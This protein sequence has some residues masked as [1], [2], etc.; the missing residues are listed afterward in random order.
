MTAVDL[1][2]NRLLLKQIQ[3]RYGDVNELPP[4]MLELVTTISQ[5]Y[6]QYEKE[7]QLIERSIDLSSQEMLE[8]NNKLEQ[9][10]QKLQ[11]S[12]EELKEFA[13]AVSHDLKEP[14]RTIASYVQL[15]EARLKEDLNPE[16]KEF[17]DFAVHGVKRLQNMLDGMLKYAQVGETHQNFAKQNLNYIIEIVL[18]DLHEI[19]TARQATIRV[20][21][22]LPVVNG[23]HIQ[24]V[25]LFQ[26]LITN[27]IKFKSQE[28][29]EIEISLETRQLDYVISVTDNGIGIGEDNKQKFFSMFRRGH[30]GNYEGI[31]MGLSICKKIIENHGGVIWIDD[32]YKR[33]LRI[34]FTIP[35]P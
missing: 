6:D 17:M 21:D 10:A 15:I 16:T 29:P 11:R 1:K 26:N 7:K 31:G 5:T 8:A 28:A 30:T 14:L 23:N 32:N 13:Y 4:E 27:S 35:K 18:E 3:K 25:Q 24:L 20:V 33:G 2:L 9:Q 19:I 22:L 34:V 12:N